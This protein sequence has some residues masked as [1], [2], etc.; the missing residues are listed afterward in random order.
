MRY[1]VLLIIFI[2][3]FSFM[4]SQENNPDFDK[5]L[6]E[7]L[8]ADDLGM[9]SYI[10]VILKTGKAQINDSTKRKEMFRGHFDNINKLASEGKMVLAG[11]LGKNDNTFRGIFVFDVA[12]EEEAKKL[13]EGDPTIVNGIFEVEYYKWYASAALK[14]INEIHKK[15][16]KRKP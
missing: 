10:M 7:K 11:P 16:S 14:E 3:N 13:M 5:N 6:A 12:N 15:I 8:G 1:I 9:R 2:L 4:N